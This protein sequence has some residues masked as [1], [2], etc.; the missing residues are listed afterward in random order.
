[1]VSSPLI[2]TESTDSS[3]KFQMPFFGLRVWSS[4]Y[5]TSA[6]VIGDLSENL[7]PERSVKVKVRPSSATL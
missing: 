7:V 5:L 3:V 1:M 4:V 6:V 2:S